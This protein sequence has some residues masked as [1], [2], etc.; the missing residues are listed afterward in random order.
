MLRKK[1]LWVEIRQ[2]QS[3]VLWMVRATVNLNNEQKVRQVRSCAS[4]KAECVK[5]KDSVW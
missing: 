5:K 4:P 2:A 3:V 1:D